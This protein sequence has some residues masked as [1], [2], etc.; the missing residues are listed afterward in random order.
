[1]MLH[2]SQIWL[3]T[4]VQGGPKNTPT[5]NVLYLGIGL[6]FCYQIHSIDS[7]LKYTQLCQ[8]A[9]IYRL[10]PQSY[11]ILHFKVQFSKITDF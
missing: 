9:L 5:A 10:N 4:N 3:Y 8:I 2:T 6:E 11:V 7:Q 1:M